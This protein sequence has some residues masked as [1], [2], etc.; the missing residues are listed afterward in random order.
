MF[1][2]N[3]KK[4]FTILTF[5]VILSAIFFLATGSK[6]ARKTR[7]PVSICAYLALR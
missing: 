6:C 2:G 3:E 1:Y 7:T 4:T 5:S